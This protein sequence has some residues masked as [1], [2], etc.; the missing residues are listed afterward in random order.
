MNC[1]L[2]EAEAE[3]LIFPER[4]QS[5]AQCYEPDRPHR[6]LAL[7]GGEIRGLQTLGMLETLKKY[8]RQTRAD[9]V[10]LLMIISGEPAPG[11]ILAAGWAR[12]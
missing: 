1:A 3:M 7:D 11:A 5:P 12:T 6:G 2:S 10:R 8:C 4:W 9:A